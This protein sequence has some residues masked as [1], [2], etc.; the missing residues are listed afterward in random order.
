MVLNQNTKRESGKKVQISKDILN[1][2][3]RCRTCWRGLGDGFS[4]HRREDSPYGHH[5]RVPTSFRRHARHP[6]EQDQYPDR[7][8]QRRGDDQSAE[9]LSWNKVPEHVV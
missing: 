1:E 4:V 2:V 5:S 7:H 8:K 3:E 9:E 6:E